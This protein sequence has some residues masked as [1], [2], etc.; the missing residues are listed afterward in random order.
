MTIKE[1]GKQIHEW[2][3]R[4]GFYGASCKADRGLPCPHVGGSIGSHLM[5]IVTELAE[6]CE[7]DRKGDRENFK[8]ELA[9]VAIRLFDLCAAECIDLEAEIEKKMLANENREHRHGKRY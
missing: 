1:I 3:H 6:A 9:D 4:K 8:E 2:A 7:A 5:L